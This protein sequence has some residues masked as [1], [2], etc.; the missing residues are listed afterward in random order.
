[1]TSESRT[2]DPSSRAADIRDMYAALLQGELSGTDALT[3]S[4]QML[5]ILMDSTMDAVF[6]KDRNSCYLGCNQ[7]FSA[8]AG[9][10]P[11]ILIG[12]SDLDMP[13]VD[14]PEF[15]ADWFIDWD[16]KVMQSG[17]PCFGILERLRRSDGQMRWIETNKV[18]LRDLD[19]EV[20]GI[21][22]TFRDV[23]D[24]RAVETKLQDA[25]N[26]LDKRVNLRTSELTRSNETLR[27]E[28]ADRIRLQAEERQQREYAEA[29]RDTAAAISE[30]FDPAGVTKEVLAGVERLVSNDFVAIMIARPDGSCYLSRYN[31]GFG[32]ITE[33]DMVDNVDLNTLPIIER[34]KAEPGP[35]LIDDPEIA[36]GPARSAI[37]VRIQVADQLVGMLVIE[38]ATLGFF[39][40]R[41]AD[42][43]AAVA[44][45]AG[46]ALSNSQLVSRT[47]EL[48]AAEERQRLARDLHDAVNQTLW[49]AALT[50]ESV[51]MDIGTDS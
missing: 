21:L 38:S 39:T 49:T 6:C 27:R 31:S 41:H 44:D 12:K 40:I 26:D 34:L 22:G 42:R 5:Q 48:A 15:N 8:F 29:L 33:P 16:Q 14:D 17:E 11:A 47:S 25:L 10:E 51:L 2:V 4:E 32:Y 1:M 18:P 30:T 3:A 20:I 28:V 46:T 37:G 7:I 19:G 43:L 50:A 24:R 36:F 45:Q 9:F 35:V 23:T 13:W